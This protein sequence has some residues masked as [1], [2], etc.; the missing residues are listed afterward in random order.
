MLKIKTEIPAF[1]ERTRQSEMEQGIAFLHHP[2]P[3]QEHEPGQENDDTPAVYGDSVIFYLVR[4][5][6]L[7]F[8]NDPEQNKQE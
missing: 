1:R 2:Q 7:R 4:V 5:T 8:R 6:P 3:P